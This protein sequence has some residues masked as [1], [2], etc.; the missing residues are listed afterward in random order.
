VKP[1]RR[2]GCIPRPQQN[3]PLALLSLSFRG[4]SRS[5]SS[6]QGARQTPRPVFSGNMRESEV[7]LLSPLR[8]YVFTLGCEGLYRL[9]NLAAPKDPGSQIRII[10]TRNGQNSGT[11]LST[12]MCQVSEVYVCRVQIAYSLMRSLIVPVVHEF[13]VSWI[14]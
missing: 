2:L 6:S 4:S 13:F 9:G 7:R 1:I 5:P 12:V 10:R 8:F 3:H 14:D 11:V